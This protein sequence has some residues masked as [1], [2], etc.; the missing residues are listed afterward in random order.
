MLIFLLI[1]EYNKMIYYN[2]SLG[3]RRASLKKVLSL[4][5]ILSMSFILVA[6]SN[7]QSSKAESNSVAGS[8]SEAKGDELS[9]EDF[10]I[11]D[12]GTYYR[13]FVKIRNNTSDKIDH[14][15]AN[16]QVLDRNGDIVDT[17]D[18]RDIV[19]LEPGQAIT[20]ESQATLGDG[21]ISNVGSFKFTS[22]EINESYIEDG[23]DRMRT[24]CKGDFS[25]TPVFNTD[26][27]KINKK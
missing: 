10:Y 24:I 14:L 13:Q 27:I 4:L 9:I 15:V 20:I 17:H 1:K 5:I 11:D 18:F 2:E 22:F 6:C 7:G 16:F 19:E 8:N 26:E 23:K 12:Y 25:P 3:E 21:L